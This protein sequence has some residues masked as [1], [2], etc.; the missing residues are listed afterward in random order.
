MNDFAVFD[1]VLFSF[2]P[3]HPFFFGFG[4]TA[5]LQEF[6]P[7]NGFAPDKTLL[8]ILRR[9][10]NPQKAYRLYIEESEPE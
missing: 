10:D 7:V 2:Q 9:T 6:V 5:G 4:E 3:Q 1:N 8:D